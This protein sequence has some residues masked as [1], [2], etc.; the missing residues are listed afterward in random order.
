MS[1]D[2]VS[3]KVV[4]FDIGNVLLRWDPRLLYRKIFSE[5]NQMEWFLSQVC[6]EAFNRK[7][8]GGAPFAAAIEALVA[9]FPDFSKEIRAYDER[10][11]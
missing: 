5:E 4:V 1:G 8:D 10:S 9:Q 6:S 11:P 2:L 3:L 7:L